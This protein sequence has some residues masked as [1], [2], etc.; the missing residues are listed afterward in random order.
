M[1]AQAQVNSTSV[2]NASK[3]SSRSKKIKTTLSLC[4]A[5]EALVKH[6]KSLNVTIVDL[7]LMDENG[8]RLGPNVLRNVKYK[9]NKLEKKNSSS[10]IQPINKASTTPNIQRPN[11]GFQLFESDRYQKTGNLSISVPTYNTLVARLN[12]GIV[13]FE[14]I[15]QNGRSVIKQFDPNRGTPKPNPDGTGIGYYL[16]KV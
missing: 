10:F 9:N 11:L 5:T 16:Y 15:L 3:V 4:K 13:D 12:R 14:F 2:V 1:Q 7:D 8:N 6:A